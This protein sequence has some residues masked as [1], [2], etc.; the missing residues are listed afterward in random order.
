VDQD[1]EHGVD[2]PVR[3][4]R[5]QQPMAV[6]QRPGRDRLGPP[7]R[8]GHGRLGDHAGGGQ[9]PAQQRQVAAGGGRVVD[10]ERR[11]ER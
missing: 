2:E 9:G 6:L 10:Q 1:A 7:D 3:A 11:P 8:P 5:D 4:D